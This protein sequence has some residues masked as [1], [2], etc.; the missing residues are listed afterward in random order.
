MVEIIT[1]CLLGALNIY[2]FFF[3][4]GQVHRLVNKL[5]SRNYQEY[6]FVKSGPPPKE[7]PV[8][9]LESEAE[10]VAILNELNSFVGGR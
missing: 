7:E 2:Q 9:D 3:W 10:E 1:I 8:V 5:M 6:D 4:S